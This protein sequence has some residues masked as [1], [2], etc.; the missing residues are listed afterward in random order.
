MNKDQDEIVSGGNLDIPDGFFVYD[1]RVDDAD[2]IVEIINDETGEERTLKVPRALAY[3]LRTHDCGSAL[4]RQKI[5]EN[6]IRKMQKNLRH[7]LG[8]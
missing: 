5:E 2:P 6:A 1:L 4:M 3:Y 7:I 8:L